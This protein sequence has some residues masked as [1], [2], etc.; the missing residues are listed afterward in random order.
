MIN[1]PDWVL[2]LYPVYAIVTFYLFWKL[3]E[4]LNI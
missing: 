1:V 2:W 4:W 3:G